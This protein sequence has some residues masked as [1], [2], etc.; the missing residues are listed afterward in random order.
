ML[1]TF[2]DPLSPL[3]SQNVMTAAFLAFAC[4]CILLRLYSQGYPNSC[5]PSGE[6]CVCVEVE[7]EERG[8]RAGSTWLEEAFLRTALLVH[9]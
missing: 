4:V 9:A 6:N 7:T 3:L 5:S 1:P 8:S 2:Y